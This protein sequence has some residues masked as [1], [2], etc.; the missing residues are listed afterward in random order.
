MKELWGM[1]ESNGERK[2]RLKKK[3]YL[4]VP[5]CSVY[6]MGYQQCMHGIHIPVIVPAQWHDCT[7]VLLV[8]SYGM[9]S[10]IFVLRVCIRTY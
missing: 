5:S 8:S 9:L 4:S 7:I 6:T 10:T 1:F 3:N 2:Y